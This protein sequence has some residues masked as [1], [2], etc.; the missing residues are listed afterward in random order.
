MNKALYVIQN[1][2]FPIFAKDIES[3]RDYLENYVGKL[4]CPTPGCYAQLDYVE[5]PYYFRN[6][7][8]FRTHKGSEHNASCPYCI[9]HQSANAPSFSSET[10]SQA[11]SDE[12]V[13]S[14]LRGLYQR[15]TEPLHVGSSFPKKGI[16]KHH[17]DTTSSTS[18]MGR[19]VASLDSNAAPVARGEREPSVRKRRSQDLLAEDNNRLRGIDG[20]VDSA[21]IDDAYIELHFATTGCPVTLLFYN[22]FRDKSEHAYQ[23][24]KHLAHLLNASDLSILVCCLGVVEMNDEKAIIQIMSPDYITIEGLSIPSYMALLAS[25]NL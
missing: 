17:D 20:T 16:S 21:Y 3:R 11:I 6:E 4:C 23:L 19:A 15:N 9:V 24:V 12:H 7:K 2:S 22:A 1:K 14:I 8:I 13:K 10:F 25:K 5:L 18:A